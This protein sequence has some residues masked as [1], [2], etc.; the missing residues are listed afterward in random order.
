M[1]TGDNGPYYKTVGST[2]PRAFTDN[3]RELI[4]QYGIDSEGFFGHRGRSAGV[5][6]IDSS[7]PLGTAEHF[8]D[9]A[10]CGGHVTLELPNGGWVT[11]LEDGSYVTFRPDSRSSSPAVSL[12]IVESSRVQSQKIHFEEEQ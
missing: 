5:R 9:V 6:Q 1:G 12:N 3:E 8:A 10:A 4:D 2:S 7:D 11:R